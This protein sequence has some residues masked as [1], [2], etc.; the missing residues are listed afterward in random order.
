[1]SILKIASSYPVI[2]EMLIYRNTTFNPT[3]TW[4]DKNGLIDWTG[5]TGECILDLGPE[6]TVI[7]LTIDNG[8][9][10]L[11]GTDGTMKLFMDKT[12]TAAIT[13]ERGSFNIFFTDV[14][15]NTKLLI[16]GKVLIEG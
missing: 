10:I 5:S 14:L 8:G 6:N 16:K 13:E 11:G 9:F 2:G 7:N 3:L 1:M 4:R 15:G 12:D